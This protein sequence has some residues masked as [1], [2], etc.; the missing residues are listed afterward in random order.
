MFSLVLPAFA[1]LALLAQTAAPSLPGDPAA[2]STQEVRGPSPQQDH[3]QRPN[4]PQ[5]PSPLP[6]EQTAG[7][8]T[9]VPQRGTIVGTVTDVNDD[10][11]PGAAVILQDPESSDVRTV[12]TNDNGFFEIR[13]VEPGS[14]YHVTISARGFAGW[15]SPVVILDPGQYKILDVSKV[16]IEEV[17]TTVTVTPESSE[18][19]AIQQVKIEEKQR[20]FGIIPNFF[21]VYGSNPA[22]LTA[23]LKFS[24]ALRVVRDPFT[25]AGVAMLAGIGQA[26]GTPDYVQGARGFAERFGANYANQFTDIM[27]GGAILPSLLHQDPRYYYQGT[28]TRKSRALHAISDLFI[29]KGDNGRLQPNYSSLGGDLAS[30]AISNLYYPGSNRGAGLV[31]QNF[32]IDSAVHMGVRLLQEFVFRPTKGTTVRDTGNH[33]MQSN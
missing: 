11:V 13:D 17:Q 29:T 10:P 23:R 25:A 31:F 5:R 20:G 8:G 21:E 4:Q 30:A 7:Q 12:T 24:L 2:R 1:S 28:G 18:E 6:Q 32:A 27:I 16:R 33:T 14:P 22:P 9:P 3:S 19:I 15:A 26:A